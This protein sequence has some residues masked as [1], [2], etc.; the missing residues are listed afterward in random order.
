MDLWVHSVPVDLVPVHFSAVG[1]LAVDYTDVYDAA[2]DL[3]VDLAAVDDSAA[4][5]MAV[6]L[7]NVDSVE[8]HREWQRIVQSH[9]KF[10]VTILC[11]SI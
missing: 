8:L 11:Y 2:V 9:S 6:E 5:Y 7:S 4:V 1:S 3:V 10:V